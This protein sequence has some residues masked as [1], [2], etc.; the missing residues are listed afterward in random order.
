[1]P[2]L[3]PLRTSTA[4]EPDESGDADARVAAVMEPEA[5]V[6]DGELVASASSTKPVGKP[7]DAKSSLRLRELGVL[8]C[9]CGCDRGRIGDAPAS[10]LAMLVL[11]ELV[12]A[13]S[14]WCGEM[15]DDDDGVVN[16]LDGDADGDEDEIDDV[17]CDDD[18]RRSTYCLSA[19]DII[20]RRSSLSESLS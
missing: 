16:E 8:G 18:G 19:S 4:G 10:T 2:Q 9:C 17:P 3:V 15:P 20:E 13:A 6:D 11:V 12:L 14:R 5:E 1:V 7:S